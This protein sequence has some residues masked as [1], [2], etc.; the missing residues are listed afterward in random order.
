MSQAA[1]SPVP[2]QTEKTTKRIAVIGAGAAGIC[3]AKYLREVEF[4]VT[5]FEIGSQIGGMWCYQNDNGL[6][7]RR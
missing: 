6:S 5:I 7:S 3:M 2:P 4:D 1:T